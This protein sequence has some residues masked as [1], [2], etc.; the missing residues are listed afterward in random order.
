MRASDFDFSLPPELIAQAPAARRDQSRLLVLDRATGRIAHRRFPDLA[1][2]FS[3]GDL[4]VLNDSRV[5]PA[6]LR[7]RNARTGGQFEVLLLEENA[8]NDWWAM[9]RPGKRAQLGTKI[10]ILDKAENPSGLEAIVREINAEGHRRLQFSGPKN[11][12]TELEALGQT[13]LPPYIQRPEE[14]L[15]DRERYQTVY[16]R[17]AGSVA[18]PTAGLHF[19]PDL[20]E[21]IRARG[22]QVCFVTL[23]VGLG[24]FAPVKAERVEDHV[25]HAE[26]FVLPAETADAIR[27]AKGSGR[28]VVAAGTTTLRVLESATQAGAGRTSVFIHP[29]HRFLVVNSLVT[30]FHL[31]RSTLLMLA[32]A[33][34]APGETRGRELILRTYEEAAAQRYRFFSYG[35]AMLLQ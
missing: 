26:R 9:M 13:P 29:P 6:R 16:A 35:D 32:A 25:M 5:I 30:N 19:T 24:T 17:A 27:Q 4:L 28:R 20:L 23:H 10:Q 3:A 2:Y 34:A 11:I 15:E 7:A 14:R 33:F 21:K 8:A 12:L 18:A 22:A 1:E 31:P